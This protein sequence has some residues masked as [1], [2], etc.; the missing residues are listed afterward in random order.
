MKPLNW[1]IMMMAAFCLVFADGCK[2]QAKPA[3]WKNSGTRVS[4]SEL[5]QAFKDSSDKD[6]QAWLSEVAVG[7][8]Y[9]EYPNSMAALEKLANQPGLTAKQKEVT[10]EVV[11]QVKQLVEKSQAS[12]GN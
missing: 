8:R 9:G 1:I 11:G 10:S 3:E 7:L 12:H 6:V 4:M 5:R 2:Q